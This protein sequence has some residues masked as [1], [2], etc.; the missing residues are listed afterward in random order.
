MNGRFYQESPPVESD[1]NGIARTGS[2]IVRLDGFTSP[3]PKVLSE[4]L[5]VQVRG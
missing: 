2:P 4:G 1:A 5:G 3:T